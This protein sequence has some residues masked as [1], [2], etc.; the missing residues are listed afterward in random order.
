MDFIRKILFIPIA[1][2][3]SILAG[4]FGFYFGQ[5]SESFFVIDIGMPQGASGIF[6]AL[7]FVVVGLKLYPNPTNQI[8]NL[9]AILIIIFGIVSS[10]GSYMSGD[11]GIITGVAMILGGIGAFRMSVEKLSI[12]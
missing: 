7:A 6:S 4:I 8:K 9:L 1:F 2:M 3:A 10:F 11:I 12:I 5:I